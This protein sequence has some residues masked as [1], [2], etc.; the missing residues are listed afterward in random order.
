MTK[1]EL[2]KLVAEF[3]DAI[4]Q[5]EVEQRGWPKWTYGIS[6]LAINLYC[7]ILGH[8]EEVLKRG[9]QVYSCCPGYVA[10]DMTSHKGTLSVDDGIKTPVHLIELPF[11]VNKELQGGFF[12]K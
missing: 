4:A 1:E 5:N 2:V 7:N 12:Q 9:I 11:E 10:T 8:Q 6:K 3:K